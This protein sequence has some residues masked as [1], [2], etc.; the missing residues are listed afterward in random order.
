M[1]MTTIGPLG[2]FAVNSYLVWD[3]ELNAV[4]IDAP[5]GAGRIMS[6]VREKGVKLGKILLTHGHCDHIESAYDIAVETGAQVYVHTLDK[7]KLSNDS[8]NLSRYF[9]M[10]PVTPVTNAL[11][12]EDGD[13]ITHASLEFEVLHSPGHT[14]GSVCLIIDDVM[15]SGDT[16]F[17][18]SMGR[19]DMPDGDNDVMMDTLAMLYDFDTFTD[20]KVFPGHGDSTTM[21]RERRENSCMLYAA[22]QAGLIRDM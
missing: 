12:F 5:E 10:P 9:G 21:F 3:D 15:F 20:Y 1:Q 8:T 2:P 11:A 18:G 22:R 17:K 19:T 7:P 14:S 6:V 13:V 4:L 16:L